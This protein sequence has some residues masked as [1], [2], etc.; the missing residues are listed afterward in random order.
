MM[1]KKT[2]NILLFA[3]LASAMTLVHA[4]NTLTHDVLAF[5]YLSLL[6][7]GGASVLGGVGRTLVSQLRKDRFVLNNRSEALKDVVIS[8]IGGFFVFVVIAGWNALAVELTIITLP[9]INGDLRIILLIITG[10]SSGKWL[11]F[12]DT[13]ASDAATRARSE[14]LGT[15][16]DPSS[17]NAPLENK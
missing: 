8:L 15:P 3:W 17:I 2:I 9:K 13:L 6:F 16:V 14:V 10:A 12:F 4:A 5:D 7:A 1:P 11:G